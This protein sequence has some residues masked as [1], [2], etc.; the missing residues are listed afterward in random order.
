MVVFRTFDKIHGLAGMPIGCVLAPRSLA[1]A[2]RK[3]GAGEAEGLGRLNLVAASAALADTAHL[4]HTRRAIASALNGRGFPRQRPWSLY[5]GM[6]L[7]PVSGIYRDQKTGGDNS[8]AKGSVFDQFA[9]M[10][11]ALVTRKS[12]KGRL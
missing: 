10:L 4:E 3:Q 11:R 1:D 2:L 8:S 5:S 12:D 6:I 7:S 9:D